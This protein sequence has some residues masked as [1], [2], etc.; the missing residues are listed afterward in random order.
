MLR[1]AAHAMSSKLVNAAAADSA[2]QNT[3]IPDGRE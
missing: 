2:S 3:G 1:K